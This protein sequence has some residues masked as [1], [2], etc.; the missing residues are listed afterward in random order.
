MKK[1]KIFIVAAFLTILSVMPHTSYATYNKAGAINISANSYITDKIRYPAER[2]TYVM[3]TPSNGLISIEF[4]YP[5]DVDEI[6]WRILVLANGHNQIIN[7]KNSP[8]DPVVNGKKVHFVKKF[9][10]NMSVYVVVTSFGKF[11]NSEYTLRINHTPESTK[12]A[13][14]EF[15]N[16]VYLYCPVIDFE[17]DFKANLYNEYDI[18][19]FAVRLE[20]GGEINAV[21]T[22][23]SNL[24]EDSFKIIIENDDKKIIAETV[25]SADEKTV[26]SVSNLDQGLYFIKIVSGKN[27]SN[28]DYLIRIEH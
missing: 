3:G 7:E 9:R 28:N 13:E 6:S 24:P 12:N 14:T 2:N 15:T 23:L 16:N 8:D 25:N 10:T 17:N 20:N 22:K 26:L 11:N 27:Y 4:E 5:A 21:L 19:L 18:D 1:C